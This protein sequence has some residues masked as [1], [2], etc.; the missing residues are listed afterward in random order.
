MKFN[1]D[2]LRQR[3]S[4]MGFSQEEL[5]QKIGSQHPIVSQWETGKRCPRGEKRR[6]LAKVLKCKTSDFVVRE[7]VS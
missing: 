7:E 3:R 4:E 2:F 6:L 5:A 1:G